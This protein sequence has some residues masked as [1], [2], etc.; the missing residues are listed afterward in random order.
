MCIIDRIHMVDLV[1]EKAEGLAKEFELSLIHI[2]AY[3]MCSPGTSGR[4][5]VPFQVPRL[6][7]ETR[8]RRVLSS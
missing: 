3:T 5:T 8:P 2:W 4:V 7:D 6:L 1:K